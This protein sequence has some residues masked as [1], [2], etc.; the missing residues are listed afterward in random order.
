MIA[1]DTLSSEI[2]LVVSIIL[3]AMILA[4]LWLTRR[5]AITAHAQLPLED[6][7]SSTDTAAPLQKDSIDG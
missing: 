6:A 2:A 4:R 3:F 7:A 1:T 5:S